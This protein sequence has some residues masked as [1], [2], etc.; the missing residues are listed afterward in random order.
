[1]TPE[2]R[3][4]LEIR[5]HPRLNKKIKGDYRL[6]LPEERE[7]RFPLET[8]TI[9][10]GGL[11]FLSSHP[12]Q[13]GAHLEFRLFLKERP[14]QFTAQAVWIK[15]QPDLENRETVYATGFR[16]G[17]ITQEDITKLLLG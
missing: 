2:Q 3:T 13:E 14:I 9:S 12:I 6:I 11:M 15:E 8:E 10:G 17:V 7:E 16:F 4:G 5:K 1:M